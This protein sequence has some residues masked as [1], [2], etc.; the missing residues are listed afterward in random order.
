M[1]F[2]DISDSVISFSKDN[3]IIAVVAGLLLLFLLVR[4]TKLFLV[5]L[6]LAFVLAAAF[7]FITDVASVGKA[8]KG[9]M[10]KERVQP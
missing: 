5:I 2:S 1:N 6:L 10:I 9:E 8:G 7:Y 3:P 4:K